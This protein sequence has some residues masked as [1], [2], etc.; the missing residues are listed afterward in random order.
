[1]A[2]LIKKIEV[3]FDLDRYEEVL[4]LGYENLY[5]SNQDQELLYSYIILSHINLNEFKKALKV[6]D[7]ALGRYPVTPALMFYR[8]KALYYLSYYQK[9]IKDIKDAL[10]FQPNNPRYLE[11]FARI[12]IT[13]D[14]FKEAQD[15]ILKALDLDS[16]NSEIKITLVS[17]L[18]LLDKKKEAK[19]VLDEVL[20]KDPYNKE[21]LDIKQRYFTPKLKSKKEILKNILFLD[22]F[23]KRIQKEIKFIKYFYIFVP[24][25]M[26][27]VVV[28]DYFLKSVHK[29]SSIFFIL[30]LIT[31]MIGSK[32]WRLNIPFLAVIFTLERYFGVKN[33]T[34]LENIFYIFAE[35]FIFHMLFSSFYMLLSYLIMKLKEIVKQQKKSKINPVFYFL[36]IAPFEKHEEIDSV[37]LKKYYKNM[38]FLIPLTL[39]LFYLYNFYFQY[40]FF[41]VIVVILFAITLMI[42]IKNFWITVSFVFVALLI[43]E[44]FTCKSCFENIISSL[45]VAV[46]FWVLY[47]LFRRFG[48]MKD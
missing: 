3:L 27:A 38:F 20:E 16:Q 6:A 5:N 48:W 41:K 46:F 44:E 35:A 26:I 42:S 32:D 8:S 34:I 7:E 29:D 22:P 21:A 23:N 43:A 33:Y 45:L 31:G 47:N 4:K 24:F 1:M 18:I 40:Q 28:L 9:A 25:L 17:V 19:R 12:L 11:H 36:F 10:E 37:L 13:Q 39:F 15:V 14:R 2:E 30:V